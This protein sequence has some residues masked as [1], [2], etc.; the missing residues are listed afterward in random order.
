MVPHYQP[1]CDTC[2]RQSSSVVYRA[3]FIKKNSHSTVVKSQQEQKVRYKWGRLN[4]IPIFNAH[5][6]CSNLFY[7]IIL[8]IWHLQHEPCMQPVK[9]HCGIKNNN[10]FYFLMGALLLSVNSSGCNIIISYSCKAPL[11]GFPT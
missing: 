11:T 6:E 3:L 9:L 7:I 10:G 4:I 1:C 2:D 5:W 8:I